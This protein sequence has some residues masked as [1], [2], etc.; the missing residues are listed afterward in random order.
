MQ[1]VFLD[2]LTFSFKEIFLGPFDIE[3]DHAN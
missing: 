3:S 1:E 2:T